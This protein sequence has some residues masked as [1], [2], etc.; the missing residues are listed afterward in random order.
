MI[1]EILILGYRT[2]ILYFLLIIV[3]RI[4]G[5]R[6]I[7]NLSTFDI[8]VFFVISELFSLSLN[9]IDNSILHSVVPVMIIVVL[10]IITAF[11]SLKSKK[12]RRISEGTHTY[13]IKDGK[14]D[15]GAMKKERYNLDDFMYQLSC[16][17][18]IN[19]KNIKDAILESTGALT[20]IL[21]D[22]EIINYEL[23][24]MEGKINEDYLNYHN[25][26]KDEIKLLIHKK[27]GYKVEDLF[28]VQE[29]KDE[30]YFVTFEELTNKN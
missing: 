27:I 22:D 2:I 11:I 29:L 21:K 14:F 7:G 25:I 19:L 17:G 12:F 9:S 10:Q 20:L 28:L 30:F 4:M 6:E 8:V 26:S 23:I 16:K 24:V 13:I 3:V 5:K 15:Y 18:I 1:N